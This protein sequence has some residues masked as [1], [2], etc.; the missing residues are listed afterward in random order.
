MKNLY[1][2]TKKTGQEDFKT[3]NRVLLEKENSIKQKQKLK[4]GKILIG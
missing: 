2:N 3:I 4:G 1:N